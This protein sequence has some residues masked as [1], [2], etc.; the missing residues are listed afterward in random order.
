[1]K[2][3]PATEQEGRSGGEGGGVGTLC[4][5]MRKDPHTARSG[6][7]SKVLTCCANRFTHR[8]GRKEYAAYVS[9]EKVDFT[10]PEDW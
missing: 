6:G 8:A 10:S 2:G 7:E 5:L 4:A 3:R 1:M 9:L